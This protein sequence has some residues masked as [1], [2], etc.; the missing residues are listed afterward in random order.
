MHHFSF[1][2]AD[3]VLFA[4]THAPDE[5]AREREREQIL[6]ADMC[7][8][9]N[10]KDL[11][12]KGA[13]AHQVAGI[14]LVFYLDVPPF[15]VSSYHNKNHQLFNYSHAVAIGE[16]ARHFFCCSSSNPPV[17]RVGLACGSADN[18]LSSNYFHLPNPLLSAEPY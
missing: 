10:A 17:A 16:K 6:H 4:Y 14:I 8:H 18:R 11:L 13:Y 9:N 15:V 5:S 7:A 2:T 12:V 3:G 1:P